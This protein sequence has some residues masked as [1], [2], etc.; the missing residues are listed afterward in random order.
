M[1]GN[2]TPEGTPFSLKLDADGVNEILVCRRD[3]I[4][5]GMRSALDDPNFSDEPS[6]SK[7]SQVDFKTASLDFF[8][9]LH[10]SRMKKPRR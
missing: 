6:T 1:S 2:S 9:V 8:Y 3:Y 7:W 5:L 10:R 4:G